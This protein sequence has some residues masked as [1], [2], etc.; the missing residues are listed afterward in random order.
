MERINY[1]TM[2]SGDVFGFDPATGVT[3]HHLKVKLGSDDA[4]P[5][6]VATHGSAGIDLYLDKDVT[7]YPGM[8]PVLIGTGVHV[9]IPQGYVGILS[10]RSGVSDS[11]MNTGVGIID[12]DYRGE[13]KLKLSAINKMVTYSKGDRLA[14]LVIIPFLSCSISVVDELSRTERGEG[15]FHST[16]RQ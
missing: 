12:A 15:G 16:G 1:I 10:L 9:Q 2:E 14:Q 13:I 6:K 3:S 4:T 11:W 7:V 5:P 8:D